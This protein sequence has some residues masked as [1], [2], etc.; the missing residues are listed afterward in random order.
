MALSNGRGVAGS[1]TEGATQPEDA[2]GPG[3]LAS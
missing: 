2:E 3:L 1:V